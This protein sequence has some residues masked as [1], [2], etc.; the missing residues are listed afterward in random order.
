M[1]QRRLAFAT[2]LPFLLLGRDASRTAEAASPAEPNCGDPGGRF[3]ACSAVPLPLAQAGAT[4]TGPRRCP[5]C[6]G[7]HAAMV[8]R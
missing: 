4:G 8:E 7:R 2:A 3:I 5:L 6:G 1:I